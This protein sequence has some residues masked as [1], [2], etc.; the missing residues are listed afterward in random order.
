ML[1]AGEPFQRQGGSDRVQRQLL[2]GDFATGLPAAAEAKKG[3]FMLSFA[4]TRENLDIF[5]V[6]FWL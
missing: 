4:N 1:N 5:A 2:Q 3:V 6:L